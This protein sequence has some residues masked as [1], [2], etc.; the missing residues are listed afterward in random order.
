MVFGF[1]VFIGDVLDM[2]TLEISLKNTRFGDVFASLL[3]STQLIQI[4]YFNP[5]TSNSLN[6]P[7]KKSIS[8]KQ[9][10]VLIGRDS[11]ANLYLDAPTISRRHATIDSDHHGRYILQNF[12]PNGVFINGQ[13]ISD[14]AILTN[15]SKIHIGP[16]ILVLRDDNL[17]ILDLSNK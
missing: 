12:S 10:S 7:T 15:R 11:T 9:K 17:E 1:V 14:K 8:L 6:P 3:A 13:Q 2:D 4:K 16:Y 5:A